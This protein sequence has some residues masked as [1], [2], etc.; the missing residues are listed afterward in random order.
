MLFPLIRSRTRVYGCIRRV[1]R[2]FLLSF[3]TFPSLTWRKRSN[4][5]VLP[6]LLLLLLLLLLLPF[7]P[8][9]LSVLA[10]SLTVPTLSVLAAT[11]ASFLA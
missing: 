3:L 1:G 11:C 2:C 5:F 8:P 6:A 9:L 7:A 10:L 4:L